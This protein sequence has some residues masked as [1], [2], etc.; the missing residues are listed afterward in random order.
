MMSQSFSKVEQE[1]QLFHAQCYMI[2]LEVKVNNLPFYPVKSFIIGSF[3]SAWCLGSTPILT[4]EGI[5]ESQSSEH[6][7]G[8]QLW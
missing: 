3:V 4:T 5:S 8:F 2:T 6:S 7:G 1:V